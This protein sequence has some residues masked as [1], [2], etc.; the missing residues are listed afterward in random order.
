VEDLEDLNARFGGLNPI[1]YGGR[2]EASALNVAVPQQILY[3]KTAD[4]IVGDYVASLGARK[5]ELSGDQA[6]AHWTALQTAFEKAFPTYKLGYMI[7]YG[8]YGLALAK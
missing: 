4:K 5:A 3:L 7:Q 6:A 2:G 1:V 8:V